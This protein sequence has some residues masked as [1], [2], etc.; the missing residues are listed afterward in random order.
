MW[1][2]NHATVFSHMM[3]SKVCAL[4]HKQV[5]AT[6]WLWGWTFLLLLPPCQ[7]HPRLL[8]G[9]SSP[10]T[11]PGLPGK[12]AQETLRTGK[13]IGPLCWHLE[14]VPVTHLSFQLLVKVPCA[15]LH[16]AFTFFSGSLWLLHFSPT[17]C[18]HYWPATVQE[19]RIYL[20]IF[21][22]TF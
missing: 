7:V 21:S 3:S 8:N 4:L 5:Q 16:R 19:I 2:M 13:T 14:Q 22:Y 18:L 20:L 10:R 12:Q 6:L 17:T 15:A 1:P 11:A 9:R